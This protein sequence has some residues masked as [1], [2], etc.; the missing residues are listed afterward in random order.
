ME[1]LCLALS[2]WQFKCLCL[3]CHLDMYSMRQTQSAVHVPA[4]EHVKP[5]YY[6]GVMF[7]M[8]ILVKYHFVADRN[9]E[10]LL[11]W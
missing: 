11:D 1:Q 7:Y 5:G 2:L 3:S 9:N 6:V 4:S 10:A 8:C